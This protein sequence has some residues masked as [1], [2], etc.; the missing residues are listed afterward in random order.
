MDNR[1][2]LRGTVRKFMVVAFVTLA[3]A[4]AAV[5]M[6]G[7][8]RSAQT[9]EDTETHVGTPIITVSETE[10]SGTDTPALM[11]ES[12]HVEYMPENVIATGVLLADAPVMDSPNGNA[13]VTCTLASGDVV[14]I[15]AGNETW[16]RVVST[17]GS[18][19]YMEVGSVSAGGYDAQMIAMLSPIIGSEAAEEETTTVTETTAETTTTTSETTTTTTT[20]VAATTTKTTTTTKAATTKATTKTTTTTTTT[21]TT[22][23]FTGP[24]DFPVNSSPYFIYVEKG[25]HTITIYAKDEKGKY[26]IA[27][28][29][30]LTATGKTAALTPVGLFEVGRKE[31][32]HAWSST[33]YSPYA[34]RYKSGLYI[35]GPLYS[36]KSF[37][38]LKEASV[39][40]IGTNASSGCMRTSAEAAYFIYQ[41]CPEGTY[42]KIVNGSPLGRAASRPAVESQYVDPA[43]GRVPVAGVTVSPEYVML[44]PGESRALTA[45]VTPQLASEKACVWLSSDTSVASVTAEGV[46]MAKKVGNATISCQTVDGDFMA[47]CAVYVLEETT[48]TATTTTTTTAVPAETT[49]ESAATAATTS[50]AAEDTT[51]TAAD[52]TTGTAAPTESTSRTES[53]DETTASVTTTASDTQ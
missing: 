27:L 21:T 1:N 14:Y 8:S 49:T 16:Y 2:L 28:R 36:S 5:F 42:I 10:V 34:S 26:T 35:H 4:V 22:A 18:E 53:T 12:Y 25:S 44:M 46:V 29:T 52:V 9:A 19:G 45:I 47:Y 33:S 50:A 39:S 37:G 38:A 20:A 24:E 13:A 3:A 23:P 17:D 11:P 15:T 31:Q 7:V 48:T 6:A 40:A 41:F 30:Y 43:T 32:W 51:S